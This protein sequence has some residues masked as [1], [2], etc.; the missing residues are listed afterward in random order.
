[1]AQQRIHPHRWVAEPLRAGGVLGAECGESGLI[2]LLAERVDAHLISAWTR[3][4]SLNAMGA[5]V[6]FE[7]SIQL[8]SNWRVRQRFTNSVP[9]PGKNFLRSSHDGAWIEDN[10]SI[11]H[12]GAYP[13]ASQRRVLRP[14]LQR[15]GGSRRSRPK[16]PPIRFHNELPIDNLVP[17]Q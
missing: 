7:A 4:V 17:P 2:A 8:Y 9:F 15:S 10:E 16:L 1:V 11:E 6:I 13:S 3:L 12:D 5:Q 14:Q